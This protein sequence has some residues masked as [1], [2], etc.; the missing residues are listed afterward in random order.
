MTIHRQITTA[1]LA[2]AA[3]GLP[4][5]VADAAIPLA[6]ARATALTAGKAAAR[7][8]HA[9][10]P[11]VRSCVARTARRD[12]CKVKLHYS[13]GARTCIL[14]V[15]VQYKTRSSSRLVYRFGQTVCS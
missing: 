6:K 15:T 7:Q 2:L 14:D 4:V 3:I 13:T 10:D 5:A 12:L 9:S 1:L 8:T 11:Q